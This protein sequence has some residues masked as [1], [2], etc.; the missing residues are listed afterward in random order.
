MRG[1]ATAGPAA[2]TVILTGLFIILYILFL[3]PAE[4]EALIGSATGDTEDP[5]IVDPLDR[6]LD[7]SPGLVSTRSETSETRNLN[8]FTLLARGEYTPVFSS[9]E[10]DVFTSRYDR[11]RFERTFIVDAVPL[12]AR[13][14]I[15]FAEVTGPIRV[16]MNN[17]EVYSGKPVSRSNKQIL[18]LP[19]IQ[20]AN[21][22]RI[23]S[24][25]HWWFWGNNAAW[26]D[27]VQVIANVY[28]PQTARSE[29]TFSLPAENRQHLER[30]SLRFLLSCDSTSQ[31]LMIRL[32]DEMIG[33]LVY[34]C[35]SP[36]EVE[37]PKN[38]LSDTNA[39]TFEAS[40]GVVS[41]Q[42]PTL[43]LFYE[44]SVDPL[45]YFH[46][47]K[48]QWD[49]IRT[50]EKEAWIYISFVR[51]DTEKDILADLNGN[52]VSVRLDRS[53]REFRQ[54]ISRFIEE[55]ENYLRLEPRRSA[56]IV[57]LQ[58]FLVSKN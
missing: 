42:A 45:Y 41:V 3:P 21:T 58:I 27:S 6:L 31:Q 4:R 18:D 36:Q 9:G 50:N 43:R 39:L 24:A 53:E 19:L 10:T 55:G 7:E 29:Q 35:S 51:D 44:R 32:N 28:S 56:Q 30:A 47:D 17:Q 37:L 5:T 25:E 13:M 22:V 16:Y 12:D 34:D 57:K 15:S 20:G 11:K 52:Y 1:Q 33:S 40:R 46:L 48:D 54:D 38:L 26:I 14:S 23:E 2:A 8:A 49:A